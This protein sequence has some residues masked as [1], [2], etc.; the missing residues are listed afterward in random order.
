MMP[1]NKLDK[2]LDWFSANYRQGD[3]AIDTLIDLTMNAFIW[4]LERSYNYSRNLMILAGLVSNRGV[5]MSSRSTDRDLLE[6]RKLARKV[7]VA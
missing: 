5:Y 7:V 1:T 4:L 3:S 2:T 6:I